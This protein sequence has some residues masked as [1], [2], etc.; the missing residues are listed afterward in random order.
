MAEK[1]VTADVPGIP[2]RPPRLLTRIAARISGD[3]LSPEAAVDDYGYPWTFADATK[4][5]IGS[6]FELTISTDML[7]DMYQR[8]QLARRII[9]SPV[10]EAFAAGFTI[11]KKSGDPADDEVIKDTM[12]EWKLYESKWLRFFKLMRLFGRCEM[13]FGYT[14]PRDTWGDTPPAKT[15]TFTW[16]QPVPVENEVELKITETIPIRIE[17]LDINFGGETL[18][19]HRTRFIHAMNPKLIEEDKDGETVLS[20]IYNLLQVQ[21]HADWSIGQALFRRASGLLGIYAP[22]GNVNDT[23]RSG[24]VASVSNHNSKTAL[25]I[26]FGWNVKDI[27]K[28]G[29]NLAIARTYRVVLEQIAAGSGFPI[30]ILIG[31]QKSSLSMSDEDLIIYERTVRSFQENT[32]APTLQKFFRICQQVGKIKEGELVIVPNSLMKVDK[33]QEEKELTITGAM[34]LLQ[35]RMDMATNELGVI[36]EPLKGGT[37]D[38]TELIKFIGT[39]KDRGSKK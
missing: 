37:P 33:Y 5:P 21:I 12:R 28:P 17:Y 38:N 9:D 32:M 18:R 15:A 27:L 2:Q 8:Y 1:V 25:Y 26:P 35:A 29:G 13:V 24:A 36:T 11:Q 4:R 39:F 10:E 16:L 3:E 14:D 19:L 30:S 7:E 34:R 22:K 6:M 20:P 23:Q 31:Q